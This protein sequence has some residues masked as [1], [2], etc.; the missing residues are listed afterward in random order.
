MLR[1]RRRA[2]GSLRFF[3]REGVYR[4]IEDNGLYAS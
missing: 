4:Y 2:G 3:V 1:E